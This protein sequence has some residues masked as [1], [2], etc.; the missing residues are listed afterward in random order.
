MR[1]SSS[2][3]ARLVPSRAFPAYT[4]I[5]SKTPHPT[6]EAGGHGMEEWA[7]ETTALDPGN[8]RKHERYLFGFDLLNHGYFWEA[9]D[10]W[11]ACWHAV[12]RKGQTADLLKALIKLGAFGVALRQGKALVAQRHLKRA[13][14]LF[15][16][17]PEEAA[18]SYGVSLPRIKLCLAWLWMSL[19]GLV[20]D[21][22]DDD[23]PVFPFEI[24]PE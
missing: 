24:R 5:P 21:W 3:R 8:C 14:A 15:H 1:E 12:G 6:R 22:A 10:E 9:H 18:R 11:E 7:E 13:T 16:G 2:P 4:H 19:D 20:R 23:H 17:F